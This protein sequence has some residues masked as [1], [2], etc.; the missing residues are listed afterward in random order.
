MTI[1]I[2][3]QDQ[4]GKWHHFQTKQNQADA[5]LVA[6]RRASSTGKRYRL[7]DDDGRLIDLIDF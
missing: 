6:S 1:N 3:W 5:Y 2:E 4:Q 7:V